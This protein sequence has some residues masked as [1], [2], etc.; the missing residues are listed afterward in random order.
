MK[1]KHKTEV[2]SRVV[3]FYRPVQT[4][5]KGK[6]EEF[7]DRQGYKIRGGENEKSERM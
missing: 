6:Q 1:C 3:G 7:S 5:N 4:W 2:F